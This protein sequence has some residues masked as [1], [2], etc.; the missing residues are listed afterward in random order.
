MAQQTQAEDL[1]CVLRELHQLSEH[2][3]TKLT[4][5]GESALLTHLAL[6]HDGA[7]AGEL[8]RTLEVG[9]S[10]IANALK[11]LE[12][13]QFVRRCPSEKDGRV[14]QVY[15]TP[16]G[17]NYIIDRYQQLLR[18]VNLV[19]DELGEAETIQLLQS[20]H[21]LLQAMNAVT[22]RQLQQSAKSAE[23]DS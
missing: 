19:L 15:I 23:S 18:R 11:H 3:D 16:Q 7:T 14:V 13:R 10:R 5:R 1:I 21:K 22:D 9:S 8:R 2:E 17:R 12:S 20:V 4:T 6:Y